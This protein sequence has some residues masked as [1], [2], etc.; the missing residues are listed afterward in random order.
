LASLS[1]R[2]LSGIPE[3][4]PG[5]DL[6]A[7]IVAALDGEQP[8][9]GQLVAIAHTAVSKAE[10]ALIRVE[11]VV[12]GERARELA[13]QDGAAGEGRDPRAIQVVL[14]ES[15][16]VLRAARGVLISRTRHG[17]VCANA[18]VD[19]SN[20]SA[21]GTP[22]TLVLLPRDPDA[23]ARRIRARLRELSG[24]S[25]G[26]G[27]AVLI[28]D[29]FG[30]AWR[31]G[32]VDVAIGLAGMQPLDDWRGR[33]DANCMELRATWLAIADAAAG[34]ADLARAK[35]SREPVVIV[36][37]L[38]RYVTAEDGPGAVALLRPLE[39]DLFR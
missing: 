28:T 9:D 7:L 3:V 1:A 18:G 14:D 29:S 2:P 12:A 36:D 16:E 15:V 21:D 8:R 25:A 20:A 13:A 27:P 38:Q 11:D 34:A 4:R 17:F 33:T 6:A 5:D 23:S 35:D 32:Q 19:A 39:E 24:A 10:G 22:G 26:T 31:N 30:R 37:G